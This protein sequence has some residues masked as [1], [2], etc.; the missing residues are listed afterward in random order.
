MIDELSSWRQVIGIAIGSVSTVVI[1]FLGFKGKTKKTEEDEYIKSLKEL[2]EIIKEL[3][4]SFN[5][6][7]KLRDV[8]E[9]KWEIMKQ[10]FNL[11]FDEYEH[12]FENNPDN[13]GMLKTLRD[14]INK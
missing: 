12:K 4:K 6:E 5:E 14:I 9:G 2:E 10:S 11:A 8:I 1:A 7:R 13:M 3:K